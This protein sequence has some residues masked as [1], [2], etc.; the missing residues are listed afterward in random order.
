[1]YIDR[2]GGDD[3]SRTRVR[4]YNDYKPL[5]V[6]FTIEFRNNYSRKQG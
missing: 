3:E 1:M 6:Q 5:Q 4:N 2:N